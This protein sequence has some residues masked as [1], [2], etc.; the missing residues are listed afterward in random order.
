MTYRCK[1]RVIGMTFRTKEAAYSKGR[2]TLEKLKGEGWRLRVWENLGWH[3][4]LYNGALSLYYHRYNDDKGSFSCMM[5]DKLGE[6]GYGA[7]IFSH[8]ESFRD[9]NEAV[10]H[11]LKMSRAV[12]MNLVKVVDDVERRVIRVPILKA[13]VDKIL[14][15]PKKLE[16][17]T[18]ECVRI[19]ESE[20][21]ERRKKRPGKGFTPRKKVTKIQVARFD[22]DDGR[23]H[24]A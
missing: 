5:S 24:C 6:G 4:A 17:L 7:M 22:R 18:N 14:A 1:G 23:G 21:K 12:V 2:R 11:Q 9:P 13:A 20:K 16:Y 3:F 15:D 19:I 8:H 10:A